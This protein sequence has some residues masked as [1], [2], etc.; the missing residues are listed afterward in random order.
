MSMCSAIWLALKALALTQ[1][2]K[3]VGAAPESSPYVECCHLN[4]NWRTPPSPVE[5]VFRYARVRL[6]P[7][8]ACENRNLARLYL[9]ETEGRDPGDCANG[10]YVMSFLL[11]VLQTIG[12]SQN[13]SERALEKY[14]QEALR[15][16][17]DALTAETADTS[18]YKRAPSKNGPLV[19]G[20]R[21]A[22]LGPPARPRG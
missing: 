9:E 2:L 20:S 3:E 12:S 15:R 18:K 16:Y 22:T 11:K 5:D 4:T 7:P 8:D 19:G 13:S 14:L 1:W 10:F 17:L 6:L 21:V